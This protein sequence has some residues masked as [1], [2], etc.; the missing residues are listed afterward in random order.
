[1]IVRSLS[2]SLALMSSPAIAGS[3]QIEV[4]D[5]NGRA[6]PDAVVTLHPAAGIPPGPIRFPWAAQMI[7]K[8]VNFVPGTLIVPVGATVSFPNRDKV[9]HHIYSFSRPARFEIKLFGRDETR[10]YTFRTAGAVALGCNIHDRMSG[11]IKVVDTPFAAK[12]GSDG[13]ASIAAISAGTGR[14]TVW[15]PRMRARDNESSFTLAIPASGLITKRI[16]VG[17]R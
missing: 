5:T 1:M 6:L 14:L 3:L 16:T 4:V 12:T 17:V 15:H 2:L 13:M 9:R 7:Q 11:F 8:D 10:S